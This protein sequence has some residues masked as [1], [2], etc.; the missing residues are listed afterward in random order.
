M[1]KSVDIAGASASGRPIVITETGYT[2]QDDTAY[3]GANETVQAKSILNTLV[4]AYQK[5]VSSTYLYELLDRDSS[6]DNTD[7][8][9]NFGLFH[10]DGTPKLAATAIHNLTTILADDGTGGRQPTES[11]D[12]SLDNMPATGS[13]MVLGKSNGAY[14]LV[15][16]AE[17]RIWDDAT[18]TEIVNPAQNVTVHLGSVHQSIRVYDTLAGTTPIAVYTDVSDFV[19]P[20]SDHPLI[21]EID[22]PGVVPP[23]DDIPAAVSGTAV[24]IVAQLSDLNGSDTLQTITLTDTH[25]LPVASE[26][27]MN[28][29]ISHYGEV[30]AAI[31]GGY[32]FSVTISDDNWTRTKVFDAGGVLQSTTNSAYSDGVITSK[33]TVHADQSTDSVIYQAGIIAQEVT[34]AADGSKNTR[35][36]DATGSLVSETTK[37]SDGLSSTTAYAAGV[38]TKMY[39]ANT[40]GSHD[41][42]TYNIEG[43][44]YTTEFQHAD[45]SGKITAVTR[46]HAD[47][48]LDYTQIIKDDGTKVTTL[49]DSTGH[50]TSAIAVTSSATITDQ[51]DTS[52][53]LT[54]QM[55]QHADGSFT[56]KVY[57][58]TV[59]TAH[60]VVNADG[61]SATKLYD[62]AGALTTS[63][64]HTQDGSTYTTVFSDGVKTRL[65]VDKA[66]GTHDTW[67]YNVQG[68]SYTTELQHAD[69]TGKVTAVTRTHADGSLDYTQTISTSGIK[70]TTLY[71]STGH[72]TTSITV[73][74]SA[75]T[76]GQYDTSGNLT[77][78]IIQDNGG[79]VLTKVYTAA[80]LTAF[81][82]VNPDGTAAT[83]LYDAAGALTTSVHY[84]Q[85]SSTYTTLYSEGIKTR[86]YVDKADG[87]H[88][89]WSYYV[90][91]KSYTT[92][93]QHADATGKVIEVT[94]T[95]ADGSLDYT[96]VVKSDGSKVTNTYDA[97][98]HKMSEVVQNVDGSS[99]TDIYDSSGGLVQEIAKTADGDTS[100]TNY[101]SGVKTSAYL[102]NA[103]GSN[104]SQLYDSSGHLTNDTVQHTD[105]SSSTTLYSAGVKTKMYVKNADGTQDNYAYNIEGQTYTTQHQHM[106]AAGKIDAVTRT[107]AD[108]SLDYTMVIQSDGTRITGLYDSAGTQTQE[109]I[110]SPSGARE[111]YQFVVAG[112]PGA[113][114][115][116][117][118]DAQG[119]LTLVDLQNSDGTH[120]VTAIST[121]LTIS[122]G[123]FD[124]LFASA[125]STTIAY[126]HGN[127]QINNFRAGSGADHDMIQIAQSLVSDYSNLQI[128][129]SGFD[130]LIHISADDTILLK[131]TYV[132][133]LDQGNFLFA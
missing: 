71:D 129:Q 126:D 78:E 66:D 11:L 30:L 84:T 38:K 19:V 104:A 81:Y 127:D 73:T 46:S 23:V 106:D 28:Y 91:G 122:G 63:V 95:H 88:D 115:H 35:T 64:H 32:A 76:T 124:D 39:V 74:P 37:N 20:V 94:R 21:I 53:Q 131:N 47:G 61:T 75:T 68:T 102:V 118:Y 9:A 97:S 96:Q 58:A 85:D 86:L 67:S 111:V 22:G 98:G 90:Q 36:F 79:A 56:T 55:V 8:Q 25:T 72:K 12:Y 41:T 29:I 18:D 15:I 24:E 65:Y 16:W 1:Q 31:Q 59:L 92:E 130:A 114:Q 14:E 69:A 43:R 42:Y 3:V 108:G 13:S 50:K 48:S 83:K 4:A 121:G 62:A 89:T 45:A 107:H 49:Y 57:T 54:K 125:G 105:G 33:V 7:P 117:S 99:T 34:V 40:D 119:N 82:V 133:Q 17:P 10:D 87:T 120:R 27:T 77:R 101:V 44:S 6:A 70:V 110:Q 51:F 26:A 112:S 123:N 113:V 60:Y 52:G 93:L 2:T 100:T 128:E 109:V 103:D 5:G 116:E 132:N 80:V